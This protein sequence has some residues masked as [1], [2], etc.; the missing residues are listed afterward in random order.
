[1]VGLFVNTTTLRGETQ[2]HVLEIG[3][4]YNEPFNC[5]FSTS[6]LFLLAMKRTFS[7]IEMLIRVAKL[8]WKIVLSLLIGLMLLLLKNYF[9]FFKNWT[10]IY[11]RRVESL[12]GNF[13]YKQM[14]L[15][16]IASSSNIFSKRLSL[17]VIFTIL[18]IKSFVRVW[19]VF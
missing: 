19:N 1:M 2:S 4:N 17:Q 14:S 3:F 6:N 16:T 8:N 11:T 9:T 18:L 13:L 12:N 10:I 7:V 5:F 15:Q